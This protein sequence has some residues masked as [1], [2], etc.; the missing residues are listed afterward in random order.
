MERDKPFLLS[1]IFLSL[2]LQVCSETS[3]FSVT[4][5]CPA[6]RGQTLVRGSIFWCVGFPCSRYLLGSS[7][8]ASTKFVCSVG[9]PISGREG[10]RSDRLR[11]QAGQA[12]N[13]NMFGIFSPYVN[14]FIN[15]WTDT[16]YTSLHMHGAVATEPPRHWLL[17]RSTKH[18]PAL[19][20]RNTPLQ[21]PRVQ[22][23]L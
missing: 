9:W 17:H 16:L 21:L 19:F 3:G 1:Y 20:K 7:L 14:Q 10:G 18:R 12:R 4:H 2:C 15:R 6:V 23:R 13:T 5:S 11:R 22:K 8:Q